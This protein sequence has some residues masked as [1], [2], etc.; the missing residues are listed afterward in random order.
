MNN[1]NTRFQ[2]EQKSQIDH[3]YSNM[4]KKNSN[5]LPKMMIQMMIQKSQN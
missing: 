5:M 4:Q 1:K 3:F 2:G